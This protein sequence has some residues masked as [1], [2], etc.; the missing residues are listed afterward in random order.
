MAIAGEVLG[1]KIVNK[2]FPPEFLKRIY[3]QFLPE[4]VADWLVKAEL[5]VEK[6]S[7]KKWPILSPSQQDALKV[8]VVVGG[9]TVR[10]WV[11][12]HKR[13]LA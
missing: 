9:V 3:L 13:A 4:E 7:E 10:H 11:E 1:K 12:K 6:G 2:V 8:K 5:G